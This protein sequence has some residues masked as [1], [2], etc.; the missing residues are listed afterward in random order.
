MSSLRRSL[1][2]PPPNAEEVR[3]ILPGQARPSLKGPPRQT[4]RAAENFEISLRDKSDATAKRG[5]SSCCV[6]L[7]SV[8]TPLPLTTNT[9]TNTIYN[10][11]FVFKFPSA[12]YRMQFSSLL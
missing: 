3:P 9:R 8:C 7:M 10:Q 1:V 4:G 12:C 5:E 6:V 2:R 11:D